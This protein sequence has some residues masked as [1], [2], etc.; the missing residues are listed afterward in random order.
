L[1]AAIYARVSSSDQS[2]TI[3]LE[4]LRDYATRHKWAAI[5]FVDEGISGKRASRPAL[6]LLFEAVR[7]RKVDV[8]IVLK[9][10]RFGRSL[11]NLLEHI[12]QLQ[13]HSVRFISITQNI[14]TDEGNPMGRLVMHIM[15]AFAE[16]EREMILER[17]ITGLRKHQDAVRSGKPLRTLSGKNLPAGG[18]RKI[19]DRSEVVRMR[20]EGLSWRAIAKE[21][22][23]PLTSAVRAYR[24]MAG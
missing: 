18:Q 17:T 5:E 12:G 1:T 2:C 15:A 9:M 23:V 24:E 8:V 21:L 11:S 6:D 3:Q 19:F 16:F 14:D 13:A 10:D 7:Q 22:G 4:A 20:D